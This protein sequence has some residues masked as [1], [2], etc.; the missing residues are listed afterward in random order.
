M[1]GSINFDKDLRAKLGAEQYR[2]NKSKAGRCSS[3]AGRPRPYAKANMLRARLYSPQLVGQDVP[4]SPR[5]PYLKFGPGVH[6]LW[7]VYD[8]GVGTIEG[9]EVEAQ[10]IIE[11]FFVRKK[12]EK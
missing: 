8:E 7:H 12:S 10:E 1:A 5:H 6:Y 3:T 11:H 9:V 4:V 2:L